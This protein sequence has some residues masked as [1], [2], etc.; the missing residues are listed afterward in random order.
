MTFFVWSF[1]ERELTSDCNAFTPFD[2]AIRTA[3]FSALIPSKQ[4][5]FDVSIDVTAIAEY[6]STIVSKSNRALPADNLSQCA[7]E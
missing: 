4:S 2:A 3:S 5:H 1:T 7:L 6:P